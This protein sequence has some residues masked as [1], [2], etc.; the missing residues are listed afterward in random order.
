MFVSSLNL[1]LTKKNDLGKG[2]RLFLL[3]LETTEYLPHSESQDE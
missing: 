1:K 3:R 2:I